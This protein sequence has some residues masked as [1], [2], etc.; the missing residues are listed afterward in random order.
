[1]L[2]STP[3]GRQLST[4]T[5][6]LAYMAEE[7]L[8]IDG[9]QYISSGRAATLVGYTKDYVGQLA[10]D[11]K[12]KAKRVGRNWYIEESSINKH[13]LSVHYTLTKPKKE[14]RQNNEEVDEIPINNIDIS[15][16][17]NSAFKNEVDIHGVKK[18]IRH[19]ISVEKEFI[20][21]DLFPQP[22]KIS[23]DPLLHSDIRFE[24]DQ[25]KQNSTVSVSRD[26][27][28]KKNTPYAAVEYTPSRTPSIERRNIHDIKTQKSTPIRPRLPRT[29]PTASKG[30]PIDGVVVLREKPQYQ[31]RR[32]QRQP[33]YND[34]N[35]TYQADFEDEKQEEV[36]Q[37]GYPS[38]IIPVIGGIIIF[39]IFVVIYIFLTGGEI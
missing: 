32:V 19:N 9:E 2:F 39:T 23:R 33:E 28:E 3:T 11:G 12:I 24:S 10:R 27:Y 17:V 25:P 6:Y 36:V 20:K 1:M 8:V 7:R 35:Y 16:T 15:P 26:N 34:L 29:T 5:L 38:K 31:N 18:E 37:E 14:R 30:V 21:T 13:K 22:K 4:I